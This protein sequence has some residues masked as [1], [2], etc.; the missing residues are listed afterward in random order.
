MRAISRA[1]LL[2]LIC[3]A[4]FAAPV[5]AQSLP[6]G[7]YLE[8]CTNARVDGGWGNT[9]AGTLRADCSDSRNRIKSTSIAADCDGDI[10]NNN[11]KLQCMRYGNGYGNGYGNNYGNNG[12]NIP[13]GSYRMTCYGSRMNGAMLTSICLDDRNGQRTT[14]I[15]AD[16]CQ[17]RDIGNVNGGLR[18]LNPPPAGSYQQT[19]DSA[20]VNSNTLTARCADQN[21]Y[22]RRTTLNVNSCRNRDISNNGGRLSCSNNGNGGFPIGSYQQ[23]CNSASIKGSTL[24]ATCLDGNNYPRR[25]SINVNNCRGRDIGN[26]NGYLQCNDYN[27]GYNNGYNNNNGYANGM[28]LGSYQQSCT[29]AYMSGRTLNATCATA[30]G[31]TRRSSINVDN[32][33]GQ[34][35]G[36]NNGYLQCSDTAYSGNNGGIAGTVPPQGSYQATCTGAYVRGGILAATCPDSYGRF[37]MTSLNIATCYGRDVANSNGTLTCR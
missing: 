27:N 21:G 13:A 31:S 30:N 23:S 1:V 3:F 8:T 2:V 7:S 19:C 36:N 32:C 34:G 6:P 14:S 22:P 11:G 35:I 10:V 15:N 18:C 16:S 5:A 9:Y 28:P 4:G 29:G 24:T 37:K 33:R 20:Y 17:G 12:Y 26:N 25:T